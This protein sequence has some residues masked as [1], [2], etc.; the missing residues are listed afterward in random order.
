[1][2]T[3]INRRGFLKVGVLGSLTLALGSSFHA[4]SIGYSVSHPAKERVFLRKQD[5]E[6]LLAIAPA[7]LNKNY[8]GILGEQAAERLLT[9]LDNMMLTFNNFSQK[10]L[11]QL[12]DLMSVAPLRYLAGGPFAPWSKASKQQASDF[13]V[14]WQNSSLSL[15][16]MGYSSLCK[17]ITM[18]W[19]AQPENF[20]QSG[21][22]GPPKIISNESL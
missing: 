11:L 10:Q 18:S 12:F 8:P 1:L 14:D 9:A 7:I 19:Y 16:R 15:K 22:P 5:T 6:F 3:D 4:L 17:L 2:L 20:I 13:L 21:Y